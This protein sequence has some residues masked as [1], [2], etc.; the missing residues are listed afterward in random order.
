MTC[1]LIFIDH[2]IPTPSRAAAF[3]I[4]RLREIFSNSLD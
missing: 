3:L 4:T 1:T 2:E